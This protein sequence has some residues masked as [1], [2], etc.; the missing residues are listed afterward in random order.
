MLV[1][2]LLKAKPKRKRQRFER[3]DDDFIDDS[4]LEMVKGGP[5]VKTKFTGFYACEVGFR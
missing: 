2:L 1:L 3:Y 4:E 5:P